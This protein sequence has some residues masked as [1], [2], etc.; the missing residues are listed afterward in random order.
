M[1][2]CLGPFLLLTAALPLTAAPDASYA[3]AAVCAK[4]HGAIH[5]EWVSS[6]HGKLM[7]LATPASVLGDFTASQ[8]MI[9]GSP[10]VFHRAGASYSITESVLTGKPWEHAVEFTLGDR[11]F[12]HYLST[13]P[14]GRILVIPATWDIE[15]MKWTL[16]VEIGN[17]EE[18]PGGQVWNKSCYGCHVSHEQKNF[19]LEHLRYRTAWTDLGAGCESCHGPGAAHAANPKAAIVNPAR[20]DAARATMVC[21]QCHSFRDIYSD[22]FTAGESYYDRFMPVLEYRLPASQDPAFWAD[23]RPRW[24]ANEAVALWQSQCFLKGGATCG[25]CHTGSHDPDIERN[26]Q[27]RPDNN[28]LCAKCHAS[29]TA[30]VAAHSH[31]AAKSAGSSCIGCH[32]PPAEVSLKT[33][34]RDHTM[35]IPAPENSLGH[36][37]P[38]ACNFCHRD[39]DAGWAKSQMDEWYG[40]KGRQKAIARADAFAAARKGDSGAIPGLLAI[41]ADPSGGPWIRANAAGYLSIFPNDPAAFDAV[42]HAFSDSD[43]LVRATAAGAI[44]PRAA[45][46]ETVAPLL[47]PLLGDPLRTVRMAAGIAMVSIGVQKFAGPAG[48]RYEEAK[49]LYRAR[50]ELNSDDAD[51]QFAAGK[52]F[53]LAGDMENAAAA[54]QNTLKLDPEMRVRYLLGRALNEKGDVA[55]ART[56]LQSVPRDDPEFAATQRLLAEL[57]LKITAGPS[58]SASEAA[59]AEAKFLNGQVQF[60]SEYYAAA[61]KDLEDALRLAPQAGWAR[62]ARVYRA[63]CLEKT[64]R[65]NE[66]EAALHELAADPSAAQ[67]VDLQLA[68]VELLFETGRAEPALQ[69]T[70]DLIRA[71]PNAP[72]AYFWRAKVLLQLHRAAEA[73][74]AAEESVRLTPEMPTAHNLLIRI[75]QVL[76]RSKDAAR[77]AEWMRDYERRLKSK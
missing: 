2:R 5:Q 32:M 15:H 30:N 51:Q 74:V 16:D 18:S 61:L 25:S 68:Y 9:G 58:A 33:Q 1:A 45:E 69:R 6:R 20:L 27:L 11:R 72:M 46:R 76:G 42:L 65:T 52:F 34:M 21:A 8:V 14:D 67:D 54:F 73:A 75:Y 38:N 37:V 56:V 71:V 3:G 43:P 62:K 19:D 57:E 63:I 10:Y 31:H 40:N 70:G 55:G 24:F 12:Q 39:K 47:A 60:Q 36:S 13:L 22:G 49:E 77:E 7:R 26:S 29:L 41:L 28:A 44:R 53:F 59:A 66:A 35:S 64:A 50:A 17:P 4:C 23:G 48:E